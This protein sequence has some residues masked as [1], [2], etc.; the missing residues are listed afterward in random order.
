MLT[1]PDG[2]NKEEIRGVGVVIGV[3]VTWG[4]PC[5]E[6]AGEI[7]TNEGS[8]VIVFCDTIVFT[9]DADA[10]STEGEGIRD[11]ESASDCEGA[12]LGVWD[13]LDVLD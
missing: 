8:G 1:T 13:C 6:T 5:P 3:V 9:G 11:A 4:L 10:N 2:P 7:K 12:T